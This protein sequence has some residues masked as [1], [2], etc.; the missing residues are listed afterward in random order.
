MEQVTGIWLKKLRIEAGLTQ[1]K[2]ADLIGVSQ[3]HIAKIEQ[4]KVDPRLSTVNKILEVLTRKR[5]KR[6]K[7]VM[8]K[9]VLFAR[10]SDTILK[11]SEV[12][13]R[14]A[15]S[16]VPVINGKRVVGTITEETIIRNLRSNLAGEKTKNVMDPPLPTVQEETGI[17]AI[18][19]LLEKHQGVL[20]MRGKE[21]V[22]IITRSDLLKIIS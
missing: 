15:I 9:G 12:M 18:R 17:D 10:P 20:V 11:I 21:V 3:A 14:H 6:C 19:P 8:T 13:M 22:G 16:Q 2:L 5:Q 7:D 1:K 4:G